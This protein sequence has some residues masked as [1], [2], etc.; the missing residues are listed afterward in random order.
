MKKLSGLQAGFTLIE[1]IVVI[2]IVAILAATALPRF[3]AM[4]VDARIA[5]ANAIYGAIRS[6]SALAHSRCLLDLAIGAVAAGTCGNAAPQVTMEG[7]AVN[8]VNQ[9]PA[10]TALG[11]TAAAQLTV[12]TAA[13]QAAAIAA[14]G[15]DGLWSLTASPTTI[16]V[17]G[18]GAGTCTITYT[19]AAAAGSPGITI[20]TTAC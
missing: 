8:I 6:A 5:K 20:N 7:T 17:V 19:A 18:G 13:T 2:T 12:G 15:S 3:A 9:Y 11:I 4:Q 1:L 16:N 10:A 14:A